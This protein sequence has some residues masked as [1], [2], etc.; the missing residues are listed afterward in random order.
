[1]VGFALGVEQEV[2]ALLERARVER[3]GA[4]RVSLYNQA[5]QTI[6]DDAAWVPLWYTGERN[7]LLKP[8][9]KDYRLVPMTI[10]KLRHVYID[11][12]N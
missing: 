3:D 8:H 5:E 2:D 12:D 9:I 11:Y 7:L 1:M 10:P 4:K 6:I